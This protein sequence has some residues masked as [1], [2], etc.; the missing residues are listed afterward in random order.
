MCHGRVGPEPGS[1]VYGLK[2]SPER[3]NLVSTRP[4]ATVGQARAGLN[5]AQESPEHIRFE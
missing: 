4:A 5:L 2:A 1:W 3:W